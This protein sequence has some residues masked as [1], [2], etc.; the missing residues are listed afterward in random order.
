[1]LTHVAG[2]GLAQGMSASNI[3]IT[4]PQYSNLTQNMINM[5]S[6][7]SAAI[8]STPSEIAPV[9]FVKVD[10]IKQIAMQCSTIE[11]CNVMFLAC[12]TFM[13]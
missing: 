8:Y 10:G 5:I 12:T 3:D 13:P 4:A 1:M 2:M 11:H 9:L 7:P 6:K